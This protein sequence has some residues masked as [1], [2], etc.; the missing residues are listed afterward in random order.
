MEDIPEADRLCIKDVLPHIPKGTMFVNRFKSMHSGIDSVAPTVVSKPMTLVFS[1]G[2]QRPITV[3]E[4]QALM[5]IRGSFRHTSTATA[6]RQIG[7]AVPADFMRR[8]GLA[9]RKHMYTS[10]YKLSVDRVIAAFT[11]TPPPSI[12]EDGLSSFICS[13][14]KKNKEG[15]KHPYS[16]AAVAF[17]DL[18]SQNPR[19]LRHKKYALSV[20]FK[21]DMMINVQRIIKN[22]RAKCQI[23]VDMV[24]VPCTLEFALSAVI[25][26]R[27]A[28]VILSKV[29]IYDHMV[30]DTDM[31][32]KRMFRGTVVVW[33]QIADMKFAELSFLY[34]RCQEI[35]QTRDRAVIRAKIT[36]WTVKKYKCHPSPRTVIRIKARH[37][38]HSNALKRAAAT[39]LTRVEIPQV[40]KR[41]LLQHLSTPQLAHSS[42]EM[43]LCNAKKWP[44]SWRR[45][46]KPRCNCAHLCDVLKLDKSNFKGGHVHVRADKCGGQHI[47]VLHAHLRDVP[48]PEQDEFKWNLANAVTQWCRD[49]L[50]FAQRFRRKKEVVLMGR[51]RAKGSLR[52][53]NEILSRLRRSGLSPTQRTADA[54]DGILN[55]THAFPKQRH[56]PS[57]V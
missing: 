16:D 18:A 30:D 1:D 54:I 44:A 3:L 10:V 34:D 17:A 40:V 26:R 48:E 9:V 20:V 19:K 14:G 21:R 7:M 15:K 25:K 55:S 45:D 57:L 43:L 53:T 8:I 32:L 33:Q 51:A 23:C 6:H 49:I 12:F 41:T 35:V 42:I 37:G 24:W 50:K 4:N 47:R 36:N 52:A 13:W 31:L 38:L 27:T 2:T 46:K 29:V 39:L 22:V 5:G 28:V 11:F 56:V